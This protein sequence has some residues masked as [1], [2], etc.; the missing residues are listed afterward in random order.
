MTHA[1]DS[2]RYL[3]LRVLNIIKFLYPVSQSMALSIYVYI[4]FMLVANIHADDLILVLVSGSTDEVLWSDYVEVV[5]LDKPEYIC[6]KPANYPIEIYGQVG[7][8]VDSKLTTCGGRY[9]VEPFTYYDDCYQLDPITNDWTKV[10]EMK[11]NRYYATEVVTPQ[12]KCK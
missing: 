7:G 3:F 5:N 2:A 12:G 4:I 11:H 10:G 9:G 6:D 1:Y 8:L